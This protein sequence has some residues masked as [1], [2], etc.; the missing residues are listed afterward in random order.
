M[1]NNRRK[2]ATTSTNQRK[3]GR[4]R[5]RRCYKRGGGKPSHSRTPKANGTTNGLPRSFFQVAQTCQSALSCFFGRHASS[6]IHHCR[7]SELRPICNKTRL[8]LCY[9]RRR[10]LTCRRRRFPTANSIGTLCGLLQLLWRSVNRASN[11]KLRSI[12]RSNAIFP[13]C[14]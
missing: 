6:C 13:C 10:G 1:T 12:W 4:S 5:H 14:H 2:V 11:T 9:R 7:G 3:Q 8:A